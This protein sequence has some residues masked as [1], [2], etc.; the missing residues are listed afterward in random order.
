MASLTSVR[1]VSA[2]F[3]E[4]DLVRERVHTEFTEGGEGTENGKAT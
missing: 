3:D 2:R 4:S 1:S